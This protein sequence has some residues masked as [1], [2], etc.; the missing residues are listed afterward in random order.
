M[1]EYLSDQC[2][3]DVVSAVFMLIVGTKPSAAQLHTFRRD[4][5][6]EIPALPAGFLIRHA[7]HAVLLHKLTVS[8]IRSVG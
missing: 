1:T 4:T 2:S 7:V 5:M 6:A 3:D 8:N